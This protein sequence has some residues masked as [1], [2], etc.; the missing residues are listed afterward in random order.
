MIPLVPYLVVSALLVV[1]GVFGAITRRSALGI[2]MAIELILNACILNLVAF[3]RHTLQTDPTHTA[4]PMFALFVMAMAAAAVAVGLSI[5]ISI[6]RN[7]RTVNVD[8]INLLKW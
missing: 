2:L 1:I 6:Y 8:E 4:G 5:V 7:H 3:H